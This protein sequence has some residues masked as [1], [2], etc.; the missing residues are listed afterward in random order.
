MKGVVTMNES[1][2]SFSLELYSLNSETES[3]DV[4][5]SSDPYSDPEDIVGDA[6]GDGDDLLN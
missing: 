1:F 5:T 6:W 3:Q 2:K 4:I